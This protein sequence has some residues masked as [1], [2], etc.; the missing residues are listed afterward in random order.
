VLTHRNS[1]LVLDFPGEF[2]FHHPEELEMRV[3]M[4]QL[5]AVVALLTVTM[6]A[7]ARKYKQTISPEK[8][9]T[10]GTTQLKAGSYDLSADSAKTELQIWEHGKVM[11]TVQGTWVKLPNKPQYSTVI[12]D[13]T[14]ITQ[15]QFS[16]SDQAFQVQ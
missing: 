6:P 9:T 3:R 15:V 11:A 8:D 10:I 5:V 1:A 4:K 16:G 2:N 7:W 14:K 12:S 13:G